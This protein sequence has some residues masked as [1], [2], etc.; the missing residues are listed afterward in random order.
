MVLIQVASPYTEHFQQ[1]EQK[2]RIN[3]QEDTQIKNSLH[4]EAVIECL[5]DT[6]MQIVLFWTGMTKQDKHLR[7]TNKTL[8]ETCNG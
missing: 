6:F 8:A 5:Q 4:A 7:Q 3:I 2:A 1:V